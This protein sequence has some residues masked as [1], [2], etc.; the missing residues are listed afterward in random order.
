M[1]R[2]LFWIVLGGMTFT[3]QQATGQTQ[4]D[5]IQRQPQKEQNQNPQNLDRYQQQEMNPNNNPYQD[6]NRRSHT[7][8]QGQN[9]VK[10]YASYQYFD[11]NG[12]AYMIGPESLEYMPVTADKSSSGMYDG[13]EPVK[14]KISAEQYKSVSE[15]MDKIAS[16]KT[17]HVTKREKGS[18]SF[19][20][21]GDA[22]Q[23]SYILP[24]ESS[25]I[26]EIENLLSTIR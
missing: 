1:K 6:P 20:I 25:Y 9:P 26:R 15:L 13:G 11:I 4:K 10:E 8:G 24:P 18:A 23:T 3:M 21:I 19:T 14:K 2:Y 5:Q 7:P 22:G 17:G 16:D 12:N